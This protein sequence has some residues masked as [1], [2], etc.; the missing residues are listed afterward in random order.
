MGQNITFFKTRFGFL[1]SAFFMFM[2]LPML[3]QAQGVTA[4]VFG[5]NITC[6]GA[7]NGSASATVIS[8]VAPYTYAWSNGGSTATINNLGPGHYTVTITGANQASASTS[9]LITQPPQLTVT[10]L[11]QTQIC[12]VAPNGNAS[13]VPA[14]GVAP[15]TYMWSNGANT[16]Q[17]NNLTSGTYTVTVTDSR[18]CTTASS[19][20][21][22]FF[23]EGVWIG[24]MISQI[25]CFGANNGMITAMPMSGTEPFTY[26]WSTGATTMKIQNLGPGTYTVTVTDA[27]TCFGVH[28]IVLT[29]PTAL[30]TV[31]SSTSA[32]CSN[33][34]TA[35]ITPGGGT[36]PYTIVW[37]TGS[38]N[39]TI[40][41]LAPGNYT[42]T[43]TDANGCAKV[44]TVTVTG[45]NIPLGLTTSVNV[46]AGCNIGGSASVAINNPS[47]AYT[48]VWSNGQT[49]P[50]AT[51]LSVGNHTVTVT[52]QTTG[53][54]GTATVN[55]PQASPIVTTAVITSN[56]TCSFGGTATA[57]SVGGVGP[58][59]YA[60][61]NGQTGPNATN[62]VA[63]TYTVTTTD[64]TGCIR[65][66][67]L[68]IT[69]TVGPTISAQ[70]I[71]NATC[72][73]GGS[74]TVTVL[75]GGQAPFTYLWSNGQNTQTAT[76]LAP[77]TRA[78]TVTDANGCAAAATVNITQSGVPTV[79]IT[80]TSPATCLV[81][82]TATAVGAGGQSP[83]TYTWSNGTTNPVAT[84]L[85]PATYTVTVRDANQCT[86]TASITIS[87][88]FLP[89]AVITS[90][91]NA[92]CNTPG[93]ATVTAAGGQPPYTYLW[94]NGQTTATAVNLAAG[95]YTVTVRGANGCT[96][97]TSVTI[98]QTNNGIT[99][100][101]FVWYDTDQN[102]IQ[103]PLETGVANVTVML[104][105]PGPDNFFNT[106]DDVM[107]ASTTTNAGGNYTFSCVVPGRY[108]IKFTGTPTGYEWTT[109]NA[110]AND[111]ADS[112]V[113]TNGQTGSFQVVAG[114]GN[115]FCFDG[116]IHT[117]CANV[118]YPGEICCNQEI[119]EGAVPAQL[120]PI[121]NPS[122]GTGALEFMWMHLVPN[123]QGILVWVVIPNTNSATFQPPALTTTRSYMRCVR[124][125]NCT[126]FVESNV[127]TITVKPAGSPGCGGIAQDLAVQPNGP[128]SVVVTWTTPA[129]FD[130]MMYTVQHSMDNS[131]WSDVVDMPSHNGTATNSYRVVDQ[132]ALAGV[133]YYRI[134]RT[135]IADGSVTHSLSRNIEL[136]LPT[137]GGGVLIYPNPVSDVLIIKNMTKYQGDVEV[138]ILTT[139]G[140]QVRSLV[141]PAGALEFRQESVES[142]P[143]G[144][145]FARIRF[146]DGTVKVVKLTKA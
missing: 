12:V 45:T 137:D 15:Y 38:N 109:P 40:T 67:N 87:T 17:I 51:N 73:T 57:S 114:Q 90:S 2:L 74:A 14:G 54:T 22:G 119:C 34:G 8:G 138:S 107:I 31:T 94:S 135:T 32:A 108:I 35:T 25:T 99:I 128:G 127:V 146:A 29:Q 129:E 4:T 93:S 140:K 80:L 50:V 53:C 49:T 7:N 60:W 27:N 131:T 133:N 132:G 89:S 76:N 58:Y 120:F 143:A 68:T 79:Q 24:D 61:S 122:G 103:G 142:L 136:V 47:G 28:T 66:T 13:A 48:Y 77:G 56:A 16:A 44:T 36:P 65:V 41:N 37:S 106:A 70:V 115:D 116:G 43:V 98:G 75:S 111:C 23:N 46:P 42:A 81:G 117:V 30:S 3:S 97:S 71:T 145:Y 124:R 139:N 134:K 112:D 21:V 33:N 96:A 126:T 95:T 11:N 102:G 100:G 63:G 5:T 52:S 1:A 78:V 9:V 62:L 69:Q 64:A 85:A 92:N 39:F 130:P 20:F 55:I 123:P 83:Y 82:A 72:A 101:D 113:N 144:L 18:G 104:M 86:S 84:N 121:S 118:I 6:F 125:A 105:G 88:P 110:G 10:L 59:T 141:I 19:T 91:T 26:A